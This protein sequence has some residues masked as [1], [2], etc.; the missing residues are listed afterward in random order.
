LDLLSNLALLD[1]VRSLLVSKSGLTKKKVRMMVK[2]CGVKE[3]A[4]KAKL[5]KVLEE[6]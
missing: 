2:G 5:S 6:L 4:L 3:G 1:D